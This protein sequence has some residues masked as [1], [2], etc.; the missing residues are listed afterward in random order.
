MK[1]YLLVLVTILMVFVNGFQFSCTE[2]GY[3][4]YLRRYP[5]KCDEDCEDYIK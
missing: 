4:E 1:Q 5:S 3:R 2:E